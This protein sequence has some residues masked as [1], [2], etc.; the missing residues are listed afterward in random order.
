MGS[1]VKKGSVFDNLEQVGSGAS[2]TEQV[3]NLMEQT[4]MFRDLDPQEIE[5]IALYVTVY[6]AKQ[7]VEVMVEGDQ[8]S[9]MFILVSGRLQIIKRDDDD[10]NKK[11]ATVRVGKSIGEMSMV[12]GMHHSATA[13]ALEDSELLLLT[14][15]NFD[16]LMERNPAVGLLMMKKIANL[17]SLRLRQTSGVLVDYLD[18]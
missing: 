3:C 12:D 9:F 13:V 6:K 17:M 4:D 8:E 11:L 15:H 14:K 5:Q 16:M 10:T 7:G 18:E 2:F 1:G